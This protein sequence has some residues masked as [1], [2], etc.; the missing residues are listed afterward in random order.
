M[1]KPNPKRLDE[2]WMH[3]ACLT[4]A[5]TGQSWG[6]KVIPSPAMRAV[7]KLKQERDRM[8]LA[9]LAMRRARATPIVDD[10]F[11]YLIATADR[12]LESALKGVE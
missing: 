4:L 6:P 7:L 12:L 3:A 10:E 9:L 8:K 11:P 1:P 2:A 5:E